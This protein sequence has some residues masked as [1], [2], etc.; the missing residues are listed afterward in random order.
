MARHPE[1]R[2]PSQYIDYWCHWDAELKRH[3]VCSDFFFAKLK[4]EIVPSK[5][6]GTWMEVG[7]V[8][9]DMSWSAKYYAGER[10]EFE[11]HTGDN[12]SLFDCPFCG[13][14]TEPIPMP[15]IA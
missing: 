7:S 6:L 1:K 11:D 5:Y 3:L 2:E 8:P 13:G 15:R 9:R 10:G 12:Y 14:E 4:G